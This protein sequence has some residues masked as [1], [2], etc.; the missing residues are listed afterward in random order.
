LAKN[1]RK[2]ENIVRDLLRCE[3]YYDSNSDVSVEEQKSNIEAVRKLLKSASKS[4][5]GGIGAPGFLV[6]SPTS[7]DFILIVECKASVTDHASQMIDNV[8]A[9]HPFVE[10]D[11]DRHKRIQRYA[12]DGALHYAKALSKEFSVISVAVSGETLAL[13]HFSTHLW[14]KG[15]ARPKHLKA[16]DGAP[17]DTI[18]PWPDYIEHATFDPT[19]QKLRFDELMAFAT[20]LH[21]FMRDHA[22]LTESEKPLLVSGTLIA[23]RNN[24]FSAS[25]GQHKKKGAPS[26]ALQIFR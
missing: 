3:N 19:V 14:P 1:E 15:A 5:G 8:I 25:Y 11:Y 26:D 13:S 2:T 17:I 9:G 6:S 4:G 12:V 16:K 22:K 10:T 18:I 21:E 24:A 20:D 23:L 7:A